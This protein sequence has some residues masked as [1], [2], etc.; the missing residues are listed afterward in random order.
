MFPIRSRKTA[1]WLLGIAGALFLFWLALPRLLGQAAERWLAIPGVD[2]LHVDVTAVTS[3]RLTLRELS[4]VYRGS[5]GARLHFAFGDVSVEYSATQKQVRRV[6]AGR[7]ELELFPADAPTQTPW[8]PLVWPAAAPDAVQLRDLKLTLNRAQAEPLAA[9]GAFVLKRNGE[10]LDAEWLADTGRLQFAAAAGETIDIAASWHPD[11][12]PAASA[13]LSAD[14][15]PESRPASVS[16]TIPLPL[17]ASVAETVGLKLPFTAT[18][19]TV[20]LQATV[21][22][23]ATS[24]TLQSIDGE[25]EFIDASAQVSPQPPVLGPTFT[26][27]GK[28]RFGWQAQKAR[29]ELLPGL[30]WQASDDARRSDAEG[31]IEAPFVLAFE[32]RRLVSEG[33]FPFSLHTE[34]WGTLNGTVHALRVDGGLSPSEW[35]AVNAKARLV[36]QLARWQHGTLALESLRANGDA[37][38]DWTAT[39]G[40]R[41]TLALQATPERMTL[42]G[43]SP[44][45]VAR[46]TWDIKATAHVAPGEQ[47]IIVSGEARTGQLAL[48]QNTPERTIAIGPT[49][50]QLTH[51]KLK[52]DGA[53][54]A[55]LTLA[56]DAIHLAPGWPAPDLRA[57]VRFDSGF[58]R[59]DG[60]VLLQGKEASR[61]NASHAIARGCGNAT[62]DARH[63]LPELEKLLQPRPPALAPLKLAT[64]RA[65][66]EFKADWCASPKARF[67]ASGILRV[68]DASIGWEKAA[69]QGVQAAVQ[70][71]GWQPLRGRLQLGV[72]RGE[73][74]TGSEIT[75]LGL[76]LVLSESALKLNALKLNLLGGS[77]GSAPKTLPWPPTDA[78]LLLEIRQID[79]GQLLNLFKVQGLSGSGRLDGVLPLAYRN[80]ALE[81]RDGRVSSTDEGALKYA[82]SLAMPDNPGLQA[83]RNLHFKKLDMRVNYAASGAYRTESTLE[84]SN[85]DFYDGYPIRF[86]LNING[87]LPGLFRSAL[88]SG[89]FNRHILEQLQSGKLQ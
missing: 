83:L 39:E 85:P 5:G 77:I 72:A 71:D 88:F 8:P 1:A 29:L 80:G 52:T 47:E 67:N 35:R 50:L 68:H 56:A 48:Q 26:L 65:E 10:R 21:R 15:Q 49:T 20:V 44:W 79:L 9:Q 19:G 84:G 51:S 16:A 89:D 13:H 40:L 33:D 38:F 61:F 87:E 59:S 69:A 25:A 18:R 24:G 58:V 57:R 76:D 43:T 81:V 14:S 30:H 66:A 70:L 31:R 82:P 12:G 36:G 86:N 2:A 62:L 42:R 55:D 45:T 75:D 22:A 11:A 60:S 78:P 54:Q 41:S 3:D 4:G 63:N 32:D 6:D 74:A 34:P 73:L 28:T 37:S 46:S 64:G 7:A 17:A 27:S 53:A 23:G